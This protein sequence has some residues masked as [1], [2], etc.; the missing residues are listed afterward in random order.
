MTTEKITITDK[1]RYDII[2]RRKSLGFSSY[3]LSERTG[4]GHSKFWLQNI[5]SGK[6]KKISK[7]DLLALYMTMEDTDD[8]DYVT[9]Q[10]EGILNQNI[11]DSSKEWYELINISSEYAEN[12]DNDSLMDKLDEFLED[13]IIPQIRNS[14][15]GMSINQK[16]AALSALQN[17][18]YSLYMNSDLAFALINIPLFGISLL[19]KKEYYEAIND[20]LAIGAKY[21]DLVIKNKSLERIKSWKERDKYYEVINKQ[22]IH[23]ALKNF[24]NIFQEMYSLIGSD[25]IDMFEF[26]RKFNT[27]VSFMIERGQPNVLKHY[28]KSFQI[29][30]GKEFAI[31]IEDCIKW[32]IGFQYDYD[33]PFIYDVIDQEQLN[34]LYAFLNNY[35]EIH[36]HI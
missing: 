23:I 25:N 13:E 2:E 5:E 27:D 10:I 15:F 8:E 7:Q 34:E 18:Y 24:Q 31:H 11:S 1:L 4:N 30:T 3:D 6:T 21:N 36:H 20:L 22:T 33:L 17:F 28:L 9:L 35:G 26:V 16:Q 32:F 19:D 14:I 12:Y 29:H